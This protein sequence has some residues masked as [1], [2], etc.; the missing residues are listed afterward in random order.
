E[1]NLSEHDVNEILSISK[2]SDLFK[3]L[4][5][6]LCPSIYGHELIKA[7]LLLAIFG[8]TERL[9]GMR[10]S[11]HVLIVGDPGLGKS[12]MLI[13]ASNISPR[14]IYVGANT[15]TAAGL[16]VTLTKD[17]NRNEWAL[18]AGALVLSDQGVC[19]IDE[20]DKMKDHTSLL[21]AMEQQSISIAKSGIVTT[22]PARSTI[23]AAANPK[24]GHY[25]KSISTKANLNMDSAL[26]SRFD[27]VFVLLDKPDHEMD[28][29]LSEQVI[30]FHNSGKRNFSFQQKW[31]NNQINFNRQDSALE[32][33]DNFSDDLPLIDHL[34]IKSEAYIEPLS[35][36]ML[37]KYITYAKKYIHPRLSPLAK[38]RLKEFYLEMRHSKSDETPVTTRQLESLIR[39]AEA[40]AK[41][42]LR[43][44]VC[45]EDCN[46][47]IE[48]VNFC[49]ANLD[50]KPNTNSKSGKK[51]NSKSAEIKL[52]LAE[53]Q[54]LAQQNPGS[55]FSYQ[56]LFQIAQELNLQKIGDFNAFIETL[57]YQGYLLKRNNKMYK[58]IT[59]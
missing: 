34:K 53:I 21:E 54:T 57:N 42:A 30:S 32:S 1:I 45:L 37:R 19:C 10:N 22:V 12:Q 5:H 58:V 24:G 40:R 39:L 23:L 59:V 52:F 16:T 29:F 11:S 49:K 35:S 4:V 2:R 41:L 46:D 28:K 44:V 20:F 36:S 7:G 26:L 56:Q 33:L 31:K 50:Q 27:L 6:S 55:E 51:P 47:A 15:T 3:L 14:G 9:N 18:E 25:N 38:S 17:S 48:I 43:D 8:A 13:S